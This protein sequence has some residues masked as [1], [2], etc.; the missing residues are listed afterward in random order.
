VIQYIISFLNTA[1]SV[2]PLSV[3]FSTPGHGSSAVAAHRWTR[4]LLERSAAV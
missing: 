4:G 2:N 3:K 1:P